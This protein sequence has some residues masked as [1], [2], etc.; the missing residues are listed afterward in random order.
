MRTLVFAIGNTLRGDDGVAHRVADLLDA[1][2]EVEV[3]RV[4]QLTPELAEEVAGAASVVFVDADPSA[5][6]V[7]LERLA[8]TPG[9]GPISHSMSAG[10]LIT[11]AERLY[12][13]HGVAYL[14]HVPA[15]RFA[16]GEELTAVA[17]EGARAAAESVTEL[18][19]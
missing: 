8:A 15:Q 12:G 11:L 10:E 17:E 19:A 6:E 4:A 2:P 13:F 14:C 16:A 1:R 7:R 18:L 5:G 3:R 9:R